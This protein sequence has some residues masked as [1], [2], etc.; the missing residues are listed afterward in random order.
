MG[1]NSKKDFYSAKQQQYYMANNLLA[2]QPLDTDNLITQDEANAIMQDVPV[3]NTGAQSIA[4][5]VCDAYL[6]LLKLSF[7][8][9]GYLN[10]A[11]ALQD[12]LYKTLYAAKYKVMNAIQCKVSDAIS[13]LDHQPI[14]KL[15]GTRGRKG[16]ENDR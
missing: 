6:T 9:S 11:P 13:E 15:I 1:F 10:Q 14:Q 16:Y 5:A 7:D 2:E 8:R 3:V 4:E 12:T